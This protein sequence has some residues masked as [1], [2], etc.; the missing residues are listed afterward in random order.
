[1]YSKNPKNSLFTVIWKKTDGRKYVSPYIVVWYK[2]KFKW[3]KIP[4]GVIVTDK[5]LMI[6]MSMG[7]K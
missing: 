4:S 3:K 7:T 6:R 2:K 5:L 1:M